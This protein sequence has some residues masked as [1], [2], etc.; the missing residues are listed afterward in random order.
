[1]KDPS[2][3]TNTVPRQLNQDT[4]GNVMEPNGALRLVLNQSYDVK[5]AHRQLT[6]MTSLAK[7]STAMRLKIPVKPTGDT[8]RSGQNLFIRLQLLASEEFLLAACDS[9]IRPP[10]CT[11]E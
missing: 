8:R 2:H 7:G 3:S 11:N 9:V 10:R 5:H 4:K 1:M 6:G